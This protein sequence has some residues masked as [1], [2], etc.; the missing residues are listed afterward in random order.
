MRL[1]V[2]A[3]ARVASSIPR[4]MCAWG[5]PIDISPSSMFLGVSLSLPLS[6]KPIKPT[7]RKRKRKETHLQSHSAPQSVSGSSEQW[8]QSR[9]EGPLL[10]PRC[11]SERDWQNLQSSGILC[12]FESTSHV[13][14]DNPISINSRMDTGLGGTSH[15]SGSFS[16]FS[17]FLR[18]LTHCLTLRKMESSLGQTSICGYT[19]WFPQ[20]FALL[21]V[22]PRMGGKASQNTQRLESCGRKSTH[23]VRGQGH[24][25]PPEL[26]RFPTEARI[27]WK[28]SLLPQ[29][30]AHRLPP[31]SPLGL[32]SGP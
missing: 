28:S 20:R 15:C 32:G 21:K 18:T 8:V 4:R 16:V 17:P 26:F 5:R 13:G 9:T 22:V 19:C 14:G 1:P 29:L 25:P 23:S 10:P 31:W 24:G 6:L 12:G 30:A 3:Q 2:L 27:L 11:L 7:L